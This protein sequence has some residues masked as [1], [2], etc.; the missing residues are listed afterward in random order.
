[1]TCLGR[2]YVSLRSRTKSV[3]KAARNPSGEASIAG[4]SAKARRWKRVVELFAEEVADE[5]CSSRAGASDEADAH[6]PADG[7]ANGHDHLG[8]AALDCVRVTAANRRC[9][10]LG[11]APLQNRGRIS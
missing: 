1:P 8:D 4:S 2:G 6:H 7:W 10:R 9:A 3:P 11:E 5:H